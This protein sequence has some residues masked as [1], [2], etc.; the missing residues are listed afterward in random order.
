MVDRRKRAALRSLAA[1]TALLTLTGPSRLPHREKKSSTLSAKARVVI[2][3]GGFAGVSAARTLKQMSP[4]LQITLIEYN[5]LYL[6]A[7]AIHSSLA[8]FRRIPDAVRN[9]RELETLGIEVVHAWVS[10]IDIPKKTVRVD[11]EWELD[12]DR[13]ILATGSDF[14]WPAIE[15]LTPDNS[16]DVPHAWGT[17]EQALIL[18]RRLRELHKG[19]TVGLYLGAGQWRCAGLLAER[20]GAIAH[21]LEAKKSRAKLLVASELSISDLPKAFQEQWVDSFRLGSQA[22]LIDWIPVNTKD[23]LRTDT[24]SKTFYVA[25]NR[26]MTDVDVLS[27]V[28][29][30]ACSR[31]AVAAG[32]ND[33]T[34]WCPVDSVTQESIIA[35]GVYVIG[36]SAKSQQFDKKVDAAITQAELCAQAIAAEVNVVGSLKPR[37]QIRHRCALF[38]D[39]HHGIV[40]TDRFRFNR[41]KGYQAVPQKTSSRVRRVDSEAVFDWLDSACERSFGKKP[42]I[43]S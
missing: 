41:R 40:S 29:P 15:G 27:V 38:V 11:G 1:G 24:Q 33:E 9:Y 20:I 7:P 16:P 2:V 43:P 39:E 28:P 6:P 18:S 3:G 36:D 42:A 32:L 37:E 14:D 31:L 22:S 35:K 30:E 8:G 13:L 10:G 23:P 5:R 19:G 12:F 21:Y 34:G 26:V 17:V 25:G 4:A